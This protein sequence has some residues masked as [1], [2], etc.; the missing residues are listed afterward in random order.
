[1][2]ERVNFLI[3]TFPRNSSSRVRLA[4]SPNWRLR[5]VV[6]LHAWYSSTEK[7]TSHKNVIVYLDARSKSIHFKRHNTLFSAYGSQKITQLPR[8]FICVGPVTHSTCSRAS[9]YVLIQSRIMNHMYFCEWCRW[10][11]ARKRASVHWSDATKIAILRYDTMKNNARKRKI[12]YSIVCSKA[13]DVFLI[14]FR[15]I[16]AARRRFGEYDSL[17]V[18]LAH[19]RIFRFHV[20]VTR[21]YVADPTSGCDNVVLL[22]SPSSERSSTQ[23]PKHP[24]SRAHSQPAFCAKRNLLGP[25]FI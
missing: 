8:C 22:I 5:D 17:A 14:V 9:R 15:S 24:R 12:Q 6:L 25:G 18:S 4:A 2:R 19:C 20:I 23:S 13:R 3:P 16:S 10:G 21:R 1:M 7:T 11:V